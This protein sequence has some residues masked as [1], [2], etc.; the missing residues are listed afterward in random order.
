MA[1]KGK[2]DFRGYRQSFTLRH[3]LCCR[4]KGV[5]KLEIGLRTSQ[6]NHFIIIKYSTD[7]PI[8]LHIVI[9]IH[10]DD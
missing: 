6:F 10:Y 3:K 4:K 7:V 2:M 5:S 9:V 8:S 1:P